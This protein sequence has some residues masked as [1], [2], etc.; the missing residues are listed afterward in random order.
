VGGV[1]E[2]AGAL[3]EVP[4]VEVGTEV[5]SKRQVISYQL[6]VISKGNN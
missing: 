4:A 1:D 5:M 6:S 2:G 3:A